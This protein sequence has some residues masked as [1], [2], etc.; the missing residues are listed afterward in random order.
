MPPK[1]FD[2][3][4]FE[5]NDNLGKNAAIKY[6]VLTENVREIEL[7]S[8]RYGVDLLYST[9]RPRA[10]RGLEAEVKRAWAGGPF[11][12]D[13]IDIPHRKRKYFEA[14]NDFFMLSA[15]RQHYLFLK[16]ESILA[17][18]VKE[19]YTKYTRMGDEQF[20]SVNIKSAK[21]GSFA[22]PIDWREAPECHCN[23]TTFIVNGYDLICKECNDIF[24]QD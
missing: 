22:L 11:P 10:R 23:N 2:R 15:D 9:I 6:L 17:S 3:K 21:F 12:Y 24:R 13:T 16:A 8:N 18:P 14:G 4:L 1:P 7:N 19:K 20:F 5:Q